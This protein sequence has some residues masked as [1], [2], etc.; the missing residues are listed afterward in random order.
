MKEITLNELKYS[1]SQGDKTYK[2]NQVFNKKNNSLGYIDVFYPTIQKLIDRK[3]IDI[4]RTKLFID[5]NYRI[6]GE[7]EGF[8]FIAGEFYHEYDLVDIKKTLL[9]YAKKQ[10]Y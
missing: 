3:L 6:H 1:Y 7:F 5:S 8:K 4:N 9:Q 2:V 10:R